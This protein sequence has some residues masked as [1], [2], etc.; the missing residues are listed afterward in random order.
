MYYIVETTCAVAEVWMIDI[1]LYCSSSGGRR[2]GKVPFLFYAVFTAALAVLSLVERTSLLRLALVFGFVW[3]LAVYVFLSQ[4]LKGCLLSFMFCTTASITDIAVSVFFS[5]LGFNLSQQLQSSSARMLYLIADHIFLFGLVFLICVLGRRSPHSLPLKSVLPELPSW[6][7]S[8]L[9][10]CVLARQYVGSD[11][12]FPP[13]YFVV[14]LGLLYTNLLVLYYTNELYAQ[15]LENQS[16][17]L[18]AHHYAM[19]QTYY[20]QLRAQQ[21]ETRALWHDISKYVQAVQTDC[22]SDQA[23]GYSESLLQLQEALDSIQPVVDVGNHVVNVILNEYLQEA[24]E[25]DTEL[26]L[27]V[28]VPHQLPITAADL[29]ILIGNTID[30][31]L[32]ACAALP[33]EERRISIIL[34]CQNRVVYYEISN[35]FP[36]GY[37]QQE[38][39]R[40]HGYGLKNVRRCVERYDG[41]MEI[42]KEG[43]RFC[44][45]AHL[46]GM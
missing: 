35:P 36:D 18:A 29:Y 33:K 1:F 44:L 14:M 10:C 41:A 12:D 4:P 28:Q 45:H 13:L 20:S 34:R 17:E 22:A 23:D 38:K 6:I 25:A 2:S 46:N 21:E 37:G 39:G 30:N 9:L 19:Q 32:D 7:V 24:K 43:G 27:D 26:A 11:Q 3:F 40:F 31:A 16:L 15:S 8:I 5:G 42:S